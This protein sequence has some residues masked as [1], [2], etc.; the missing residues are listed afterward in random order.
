MSK[1]VYY[2]IGGF[3]PSSF[4]SNALGTH[5]RF[6][7]FDSAIK[8]LED[9][10]ELYVNSENFKSCGELISEGVYRSNL[11]SEYKHQYVFKSKRTGMCSIHNYTVLGRTIHYL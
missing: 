6:S 8:T 3:L 5:I 7:T 4:I 9:V 2:E 1:F 11:L 10:L